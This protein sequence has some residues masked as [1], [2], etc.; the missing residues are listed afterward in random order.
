MHK[1]SPARPGPSLTLG[2]WI[3][4]VFLFATGCPPSS[5][6]LE[7]SVTLGD[8]QYRYRVWLP[9]HYTKVHHWPV[10]LYLHGSAERGDDNLRQVSMGLGPA[11]EKYG[12]RY[13]CII[14]FPQCRLGQEWYGEMESQA[15][16]ALENT[17]REFHGNRRRIYLTGISMGGSGAWY[18]ARHRRL[19]AADVPI[20]AEVSRD[21]AD[22]FP[23][24][25]PPDIARIVGA[26]DP[27]AALA[28]AIGTTPVWVFHGAADE[29]V[30]VIEARRMVAALVRNGG[31]VKY[32]EYPGVGHDSWDLAYADP[33]LARWLLQ[34]R[35]R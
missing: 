13:K 5:R 30:P 6:F 1:A 24:E 27:Y 16:A 4:I 34:Q 33:G 29:E 15:I 14:V 11:L 9:A 22:P 26:P 23:V 35:L 18:L 31:N 19:F 20:C 8:H 3:V 10:I 25:P 28:G 2:T 32:T 12:D 7:R 21:P 17:I